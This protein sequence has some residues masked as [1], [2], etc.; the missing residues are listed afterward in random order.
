MGVF[1]EKQFFQLSIDL[2]DL[3]K[4]SIFLKIMH[5]IKSSEILHF[6]VSVLCDL[7]YKISQKLCVT[8]G[9]PVIVTSDDSS[10]QF[11]IVPTFGV[12]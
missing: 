11:Q 10:K 12:F 4:L 6:Q 1:Q 7:S 3:A 9:S 5:L 8:G 2:D